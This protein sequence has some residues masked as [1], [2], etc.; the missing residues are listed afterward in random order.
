VL[1]DEQPELENALIKKGFDE[2]GL[3]VGGPAGSNSSGKGIQPPVKLSGALV[4]GLSN[5]GG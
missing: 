2:L 5:S 4:D 1:G 3:P